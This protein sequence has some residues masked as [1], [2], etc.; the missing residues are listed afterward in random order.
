MTTE[1]PLLEKPLKGPAYAVS[2]FGKLPH[3]AFILAGQV[4][5]IP[6]ANPPRSKAGT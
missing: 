4:T 1:T 5:L 2:G 3:L 6:E